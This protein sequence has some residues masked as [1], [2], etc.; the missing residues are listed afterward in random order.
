MKPHGSIQV[1]REWCGVLTD[2]VLRCFHNLE[3]LNYGDFLV[4]IVPELLS[5]LRLGIAVPS[6]D[7]S[8]A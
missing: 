4:G 3:G 7:L 2:P 1:V 6:Q 5:S 8:G